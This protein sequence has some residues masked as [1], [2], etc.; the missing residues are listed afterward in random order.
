M[1]TTTLNGKKPGDTNR[2][3]ILHQQKEPAAAQ[4]QEFQRVRRARE[5]AHHALPPL[6]TPHRV[7]RKIPMRM[8]TT[9]AALPSLN[10]KLRCSGK[11]ALTHRPLDTAEST[12]A[13]ETHSDTQF[14]CT[15]APP[16]GPAPTAPATSA[17]H[18]TQHT[19]S[20]VASAARCW[21]RVDVLE[22]SGFEVHLAEPQKSIKGL[23]RNAS[24]ASGAGSVLLNAG[25]PCI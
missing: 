23:S 17:H 4:F 6:S 5:R 8:S 1:R 14:S 21:T 25:P 15:H 22:N 2:K 19:R 12:T 18:Q 20:L 3:H 7:E 9:P 24:C 13:M 10:V 16:S 11:R